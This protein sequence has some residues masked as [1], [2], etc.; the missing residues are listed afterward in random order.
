MFLHKVA[1]L[2]G[3]G[4]R[5]TGRPVKYIEDRIDNITACDNHGSDRTYDVELALDSNY[6]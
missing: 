4:A 1:V 2:A 5:A 3:L 6:G